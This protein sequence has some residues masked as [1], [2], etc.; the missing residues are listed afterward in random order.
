VLGRVG[1]PREVA[2][3]ALFLASDES[4]YVT[5]AVIPVDGGWTAK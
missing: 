4:S 2:T 1:T 3:A 5:G